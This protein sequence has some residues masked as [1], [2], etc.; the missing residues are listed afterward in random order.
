MHSTKASD[1]ELWF[2]FDLRLNKRLTKQWR[3]RWFET[4]SHPLWCHF[5][6]KL[7]PH[8]LGDNGLI[9]IW[10]KSAFCLPG[11]VY[12]DQASEEW[13]ANTV[14]A[15][16]NALLYCRYNCYSKWRKRLRQCVPF[17][18]LVGFQ[19]L[20]S[21]L[22]ISKWLPLGVEISLMFAVNIVKPQSNSIMATITFL[23]HD[24]DELYY[25]CF[26]LKAK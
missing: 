7:L 20:I 3:G 12:M 23:H 11:I 26:K 1:A 21:W 8:L 24:L 14:P 10:E 6:V 18:R 22:W 17:N 19:Y 13:T 5:Y 9:D 4:P 25:Y 16:C 15:I 2:F